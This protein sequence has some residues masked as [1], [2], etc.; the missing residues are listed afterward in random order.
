MTRAAHWLLI[1]AAGAA[2]CV[3]AAMAV[4]LVA[5]EHARLAE[6]RGGVAMTI[7][8]VAV[9]DLGGVVPTS[10]AQAETV[11]A[12][13]VRAAG[14]MQRPWA[15]EVLEPGGTAVASG[16]GPVPAHAVRALLPLVAG[17]PD[18]WRIAVS[19]E[20]STDRDLIAV[21]G[22]L[23]LGMAVGVLAA[24]ELLRWV[25]ARQLEA[26]LQTMVKIA[27]AGKAGDFRVV[28]APG[29][30]GEIGAL[31]DALA[32]FVG[33]LTLRR[34]EVDLLLG[35]ALHDTYDPGVVARAAAWSR[36]LDEQVRIAEDDP[37][38]AGMPGDAGLRRLLQ[39]FT[40]LLLGTQM[41][42][43]NGPAALL[44]VLGAALAG[45]RLLAWLPRWIGRRFAIAVTGGLAA[46]AAWSTPAADSCAALAAVALAAGCAIHCA[47]A[48]R[49]EPAGAAGEAADTG[50]LSAVAAG[51]GSAA[52]S[53]LGG[54]PE[55]SVLAPV[56]LPAG[57]VLLAAFA[58]AAT[59]EALD[60]PAWTVWPT[61]AE[62]AA[63]STTGGLAAM[64]AGTVLPAAS[65]VTALL[66]AAL[67]Q[68]MPEACL[69]GAA[70]GL[71]AAPIVA[72]RMAGV[73]GMG[74][75]VRLLLAPALLALLLPPG[76]APGPL[77]AAAAGLLAGIMWHLSTETLYR[78]A[79]QDR[80][81]VTEQAVI[82]SAKIWRGAGL[83]LPVGAVA[84]GIQPVRGVVLLAVIVA[85]GGLGFLLRRVRLLA[86]S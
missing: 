3:T 59:N 73:P 65:F 9:R 23:L 5:G 36:R 80:A 47:A 74:L 4:A 51:L 86:S 32:R 15:V 53:T 25:I 82:L 68:P 67:A 20:D 28:P 40:A 1:L 12:A 83:L 48:G 33:F 2:V 78:A 61:L 17:Q 43:V 71:W 10:P 44:L 50:A 60:K 37:S 34:R 14:Q 38:R 30:A 19:I 69:A 77:A 16:P 54:G 18:G 57:T 22:G 8:E 64:L 21:L 85:V 46:L 55:L 6:L 35:D 72:P 11:I 84:A 62:F 81:A 42:L 41:P 31:R 45:G 79:R 58:I 56:I 76:P 49:A 66:L 7:A 13:T 52:I 70:A 27:A 26:P 63:V 24:L 39:Y 29:G 75:A